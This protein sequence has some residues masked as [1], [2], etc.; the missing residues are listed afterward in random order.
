[1]IIYGCEKWIVMELNIFVYFQNNLDL[2]LQIKSSA[3]S[4]KEIIYQYCMMIIEFENN[5]RRFL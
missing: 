5:A 4:I 2:R 1:M 3:F